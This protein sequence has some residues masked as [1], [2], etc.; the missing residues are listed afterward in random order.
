MEITDF[1]ECNM[2]YAKDQPEYLQLPA[3]KS[4]KGAVTSCWKMSIKERLKVLFTGR[5][6]L[7]LLTFNRPIQPQLM[8]TDKE[9]LLSIDG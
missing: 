4:K 2:V 6:Y 5:V 1:K 8:S 9:L 7:Q 3:Y